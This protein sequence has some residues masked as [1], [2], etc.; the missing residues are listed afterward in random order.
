MNAA[1]VVVSGSTDSTGLS[2]V[3]VRQP[4]IALK[5]CIATT[6]IFPSRN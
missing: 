2:S 3:D 4:T 6:G 1:S 5:A